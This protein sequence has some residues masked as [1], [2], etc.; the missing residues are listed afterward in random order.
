[1]ENVIESLYQQNQ[2]LTKTLSEHAAVIKIL[3]E[4]IQ[5]IESELVQSRRNNSGLVP[6]SIEVTP[7]FQAT[8]AFSHLQSLGVG[9]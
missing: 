7:Q 3:I 8:K 1:M 5:K 6:S 4:R 9:V 2:A